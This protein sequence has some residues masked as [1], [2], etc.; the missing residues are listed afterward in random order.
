MDKL[1]GKPQV[2]VRSFF[3]LISLLLFPVGLFG[4]TVIV[5][6]TLGASITNG[7]YSIANR[8]NTGSDGNAYKTLQEVIWGTDGTDGVA[9]VGDTIY[10]RA[11]TY[12][13]DWS[14]A[15]SSG[16]A[17]QIPTALNGTAWTAGGTF[18]A[19]LH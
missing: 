17:M 19:G 5:D 1:L 15:T 9:N 3:I 12:S 2:I 13:E 6:N 11:G 7:T 18:S 16:A 14:S 10:L 8:N 4:A